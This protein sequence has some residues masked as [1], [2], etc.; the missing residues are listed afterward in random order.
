MPSFHTVD[1]TNGILMGTWGLKKS[2]IV[3]HTTDFSED[4]MK[5][6]QENKWK[7]P[8]KVKTFMAQDRHNQTW[9]AW[10]WRCSTVTQT[11]SGRGHVFFC[12]HTVKS[13][14]KGY[15]SSLMFSD[16]LQLCKAW[17]RAELRVQIRNTWA[18]PGR[19]MIRAGRG[20]PFS[21]WTSGELQC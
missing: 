5:R 16:H 10:L 4:K 8:P 3:L 7:K 21:S 1:L 14:C 2:R 15:S 11:R 9:H 20:H 13:T 6:H 17:S 12:W 18:W 19:Q